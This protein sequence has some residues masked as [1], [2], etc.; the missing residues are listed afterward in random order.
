[1]TSSVKPAVVNGRGNFASLF[2]DI[3]QH[4]KLFCEIFIFIVNG[5]DRRQDCNRTSFIC[6]T[7][8]CEIFHARNF[9]ELPRTRIFSCFSVLAWVLL[10]ERLNSPVFFKSFIF[11]WDELEKLFDNLAVMDL[12]HSLEAENSRCWI[13]LV[14]GEHSL[15]GR[16]GAFL[17]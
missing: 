9:F 7:E 8:V 14:D 1:M 17:L 13:F 3:A 12:S 4:G 16:E 2:I 5:G 6:L 15:N 11:S 10:L